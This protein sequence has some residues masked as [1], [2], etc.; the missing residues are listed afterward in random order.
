MIDRNREGHTHLVRPAS[1]IFSNSRHASTKRPSTD[2]GLC[3]RYRSSCFNPSYMA[4]VNNGPARGARR[5]QA[6]VASPHRHPSRTSEWMRTH[7]GQTFP[8]G[9]LNVPPSIFSRHVKLVPR[10]TV[11]SDRDPD[12]FFIMISF[13]TS[14]SICI[15]AFFS[16]SYITRGENLPCAVSI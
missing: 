8:D 9:L 10:Q 4:E 13:K 1:L 15:D 7:L 5:V 11:L 16:F 6:H 2:S 14:V 3:M 12:R